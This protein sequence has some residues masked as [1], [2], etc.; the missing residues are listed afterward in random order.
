MATAGIDIRGD[1]QL[2]RNLTDLAGKVA[3]KTMR[4]GL[5]K[6]TQVIVKE[7]RGRAPRETGLLRRS[8]GKKVITYKQSGTMVG[9][10]GIKKNVVGSG[11]DGEKRWPFNY[12]HLVEFGT[13][14]KHSKAGGPSAFMRPALDTK[15]AEA[16]RVVRDKTLQELEKEA[17]RLKK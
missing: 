12:A 2:R 13:Y 10:V 16:L 14:S 7:A 17:A 3:R 11:P 1:R 6:G 9:V 15:R 4:K 8:I 5:S